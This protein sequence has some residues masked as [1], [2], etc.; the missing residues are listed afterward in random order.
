VADI[1]VCI[2]FKGLTGAILNTSKMFEEI[3]DLYA[4]QVNIVMKP[5][6]FCVTYVFDVTS[7]IV[8]LFLCVCSSLINIAVLRDT[9][10]SG[11]SLF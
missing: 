4:K 6:P 9:S 3:G 8:I 2:E 1:P 7:C 5:A 11:I 10:K